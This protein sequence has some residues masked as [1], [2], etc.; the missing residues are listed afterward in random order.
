MRH[1]LET[2]LL[3]GIL[4]CACACSREIAGGRA[5]GGEIYA[6][7]C[8]RC[9]GAEGTPDEAMARSFGVRDLADPAF[10]EGI[11]NEELRARIAK[12][13]ENRR[14]PAFEG[15]LTDAQIDAVTRHVRSLGQQG[16]R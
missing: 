15:A 3:L 1:R 2:A 14:M 16:A 9:H 10:Q 6:Q 5:D 11:S 4:L 13:S 12:G 7:V 8:A